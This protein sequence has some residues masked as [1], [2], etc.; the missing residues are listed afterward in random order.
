[1]RF[2]NIARGVQGGTHH[3]SLL[4]LSLEG[5]WVVDVTVVAIVSVMVVSMVTTWMV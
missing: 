2:C 5:T 1:M 3:E 4:D